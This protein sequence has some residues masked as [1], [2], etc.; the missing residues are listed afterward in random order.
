MRECGST[1]V[2]ARLLRLIHGTGWLHVHLAAVAGSS[3]AISRI[4]E[5]GSQRRFAA[6]RR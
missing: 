5:R 4:S 6:L 1:C 2:R 3:N